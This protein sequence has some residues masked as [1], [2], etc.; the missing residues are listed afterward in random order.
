MFGERGLELGDPAV[1]APR[2]PSSSR[3]FAR[4]S[5]SATC[6]RN[7]G[8]RGAYGSGSSIVADAA[9]RRV[10]VV[11]TEPHDAA[12]ARRGRRCAACRLRRCSWLSTTTRPP[13]RR[14]H[15]HVAGPQRLERLGDAGARRRRSVAAVSS[16]AW[17]PA[18]L[19]DVAGVALRELALARSSML[20]AA[21]EL[22]LER[23]DVAVGVELRERQ[24]EQ[25]VRLEL[26]VAAHEVGRHVVRRAER[27]R[28]ASVRRDASD[29]TW[30]NGTNG[31]QQHDGVPDARRSR[32]GRPAR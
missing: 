10:E 23:D 21:L 3:S 1:V 18:V 31:L 16:S 11:G 20:A 27:R 32:A 13:R 17:Q 5:R 25:V 9:R 2:A 19:G 22:A 7:A 4:R 29:A 8:L 15:D 28:S 12:R 26:R 24:V 14:D 30:S 6:S